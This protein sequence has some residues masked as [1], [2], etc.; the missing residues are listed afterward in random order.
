MDEAL[1]GDCQV[2]MK[3]WL[4]VSFILVSILFSNQVASSSNCVSC[5]EQAVSDWEQSDHAKAMDVATSETVLGDF[6]D[7][8]VLHYSQVARFYRDD[9]AFRISFKEAENTTDYRVKYTFGHYPLQQYLIE[10]DNGRLQ[11]FPF[12]WDS[13]KSIEGGQRW[14][15]IYSTE[16]IQSNDRLHW[17]QPLQNWNGMCADCHSDGL[18]RNYSVETKQ[19]E[20]TWDN[21]NV[22]CQSCHGKMRDHLNSTSLIEHTD[23]NNAW[24]RKEQ[25]ALGQWLLKDG[26]KIASW[27]GEPRNNQFM[28]TCFSC[29]SLRTPINDG[30]EPNAAFLDQFV[31]ALIT[32]IMYHA[33]GQI[34][35]EVYVYGSFLQSKMF[36]AGVNCLDCHDRHTMKVKTEGNGL[37][38]Q[39][40]S[41]DVYQQEVHIRHK[42][43]SEA[44]QCV[45]CHMPETTYMG[46]DARRDHSFKV[47]RPDLS[48]KYDIPN[49]C[50]GCHKSQSSSWA[51]DNIAQWRNGAELPANPQENFIA[52]MHN[53]R[54]P[55]EQH[56]ALIN[57]DELSV[58]ERASAIAMLPNSIRSLSDKDVKPW[59]HS[60]HDLIRLATAS[61]GQLLPI[62]ERLKSYRGLL[63]D[64]YKAVRLSAANQLLD[65][66]LQN[67]A[68]FDN[69]LEILLKA[70]EVSMWRGES[71]LNQSMTYLKLGRQQKAIDSLKHGI[72]VDPYF[73]PNHV[74]LA[75]IYRSLGQSEME[76][77][78]LA[79]GLTKNPK[80][81]ILY[82]ARG[83]HLIREKRKVDSIKAFRQAV[84]F[85]PENVQYIYVYFVALDSVAKTKKALRELKLVLSRYD[86]HPKLLQL[87]LNFARK[88]N[89][90]DSIRYFYNA[91]QKSG[92]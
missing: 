50:N 54:L 47:P 61:I 89:D 24:S 34:K 82:Y 67:Q 70:N 57:N 73:E 80:S 12:A 9:Q 78:T 58:I 65:A 85:S 21:I 60:R 49:A 66:G 40:H 71:A 23:V 2:V 45:N 30:I 83:M 46:V 64:K 13:R 39:C 75:E 20:T 86:F 4:F 25:K 72:A 22:G 43:N 36:E 33:D 15:P 53:E 90:V 91:N 3:Y 68:A 44:G 32:P 37:C 17:Q 59:V 16:D 28:D 76:A 81:A 52:L 7:V 11:V 79:Y 87:G 69:A 8:E 48:A 19:F 51:E 56:L 31:P 14:Y 29:H 92:N 6:S 88:L 41:S 62:K 77:K 26:E 1:N 10:A 38:L 35:E 63:E 18:A 84:K 5:H 74:N 42:I 27:E 55:A